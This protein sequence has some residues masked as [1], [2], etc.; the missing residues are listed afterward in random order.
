M[1]IGRE[2]E[3]SELNRRYAQQGFQLPVIYGRRRIGKTRLIQEFLQN[4]KYVYFMATEQSGKELLA[5]FTMAIKEQIPDERTKYLPAFASWEDLFGY[6][7]EL[8]SREKRLILAIDEYPYL[9]KAVPAVSSLLQKVIDNDWSKTNLYF[10][11]CGSSMSFMEKQVLG[12][13]S[14]L[15]GRRTGQLK[16]GPMPYYEGRSFFSSWAV[17]EQLIGYGI[18][19]GIPKYLELFAQYGSLREAVTGEFLLPGGHLH[20]EPDNLMK[21]ELREPAVYNSILAAIAGGA[22]KL[23]E[24]AQA[25]GMEAQKLGFYLKNLHA[26][27]ITAQEKPVGKGGAR[28]GRYKVADAMFDFWYRFMPRC[29]SLIALGAGERVYDGRIAPGLDE[30]FGHIFEDICMQYLKAQVAKGE[31]AELYTDYGRWW[32]ANPLKKRE[33]EIDLVLSDEKNLLVGEC[34]WT[35]KPVGRQELALLE[36]RAAII[37]DGKNLRYVLFSRTGFTEELLSFNRDDVMLISITE[38][39]RIDEG[40][41]NSTVMETS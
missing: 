3:L 7:T 6:L 35:R 29:Q 15:Y 22:T 19:G 37:R 1:F 41:D 28:R 24:I 13:K 16:L 34:K 10:I 25:V 38:L 26:L 36:E 32:G 14:P 17:E 12:E 27:G 23:N 33:E 2:Q 40:A 39:M 11:L 4:K 21:Q 20:E 9:A 5:A 18:C 31:I 30:F 8:A